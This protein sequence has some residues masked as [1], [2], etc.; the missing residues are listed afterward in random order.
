MKK[1]I[2]TTIGLAGTSG[3]SR[4]R[5]RLGQFGPGRTNGQRHR[6]GR[7]QE[8]GLRRLLLTQ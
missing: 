3:V 4:R 5:A 6:Y 2:T 1:S 8:Y 7:R